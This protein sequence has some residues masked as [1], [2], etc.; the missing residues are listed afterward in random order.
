M[1]GSFVLP[2]TLALPILGAIFVMCTP[3]AEHGLHRGIG[4]FFSAMSFVVSLLILRYFDPK[5]AHFQLVFD[6]EW[7]PAL[8]SHFK[9]GVDGISIWLVLPPRS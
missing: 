6:A 7:I 5:A 2:L 4:I 8:G 3:K 1:P 9:V